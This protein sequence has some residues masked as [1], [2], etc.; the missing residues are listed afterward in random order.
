[1]T[2]RPVCC[3][4][5]DIQTYK[6]RHVLDLNSPYTVV[7]PDLTDEVREGLVDIDALLGRR[8]DEFAAKV[9]CE[10]TTLCRRADK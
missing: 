3:S 10:V 2:G 4:Y 5:T 1:M 6:Q 7:F 8:L 9:L